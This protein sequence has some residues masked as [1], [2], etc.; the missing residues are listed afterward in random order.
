[1]DDE[2]WL[3]QRFQEALLPDSVGLAPLVPF[4]DA[5]FLRNR[6]VVFLET[7]HHSEL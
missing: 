4:I 7:K 1:V 6:S 2:K 5:L 3:A